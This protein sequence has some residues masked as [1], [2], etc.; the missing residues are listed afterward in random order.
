MFGPVAPVFTLFG[1]AFCLQLLS[2]E[3]FAVSLFS[4]FR[5]A[6]TYAVFCRSSRTCKSLEMAYLLRLRFGSNARPN[7]NSAP[8]GIKE[9]AV[10]QSF[11]TGFRTCSASLQGKAATHGNGLPICLPVYSYRR[12]STG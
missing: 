6:N 5:L 10:Y 12:I 4:L 1:C 11:P 9:Q 3:R 7:A 2:Q 8:A